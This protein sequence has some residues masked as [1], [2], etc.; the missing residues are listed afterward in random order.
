MK[1]S[2]KVCN[3]RDLT[4]Y[5]SDFGRILLAFYV[6]VNQQSLK[7]TLHANSRF[8]DLVASSKLRYV[9]VTKAKIVFF[10]LKHTKNA[11]TVLFLLL[12]YSLLHLSLM[13]SKFTDPASRLC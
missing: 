13:L 4:A 7:D 3:K 8:C 1:K 9:E 6:S 12:I 5:V 11:A 10:C 2:H